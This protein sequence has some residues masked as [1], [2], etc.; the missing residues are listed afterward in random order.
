MM[1]SAASAMLNP[2]PNAGP[3]TA[4]L[5]H[6]RSIGLAQSVARRLKNVGA[7][8]KKP[9]TLLLSA[10]YYEPGVITQA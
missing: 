9:M 7:E 4:A 3:S 1:K 8:A 5:L 10:T 6:L 2:A